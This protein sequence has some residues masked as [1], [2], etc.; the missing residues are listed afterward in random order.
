M[1]SFSVDPPK[2]IEHPNSQSVPTGSQAT[3]TIEVTGDDLTFQWQKNDNDVHNGS[4]Y[5]GAD[6]NTL[7]IQH[8]KKSH[9]GCYRCLVKND[10]KKDGE[11]SDE[12]QLTIRESSLQCLSCTVVYLIVFLVNHT[13]RPISTLLVFIL[14][15]Q[16]NSFHS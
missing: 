8:V 1:I 6:T 7:S 15:V 10:V 14:L 12:A 4:N 3:F 13:M 2:I 11:I 5:S 9:A 16:N